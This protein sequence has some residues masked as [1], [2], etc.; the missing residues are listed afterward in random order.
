MLAG[1]CASSRGTTD[2]GH[3]KRFRVICMVIK[4]MIKRF[5]VS[6]FMIFWGDP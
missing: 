4:K 1:N 6:M 5:I 2:D 3:M